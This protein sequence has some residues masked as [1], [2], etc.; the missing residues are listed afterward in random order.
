MEKNADRLLL[1]DARAP[2]RFRGEQ[3]PI[4]PVAGHP[5]GGC[6]RAAPKSGCTAGSGAN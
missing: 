1:L 6:G 4:D 5:D 2:V 3:E